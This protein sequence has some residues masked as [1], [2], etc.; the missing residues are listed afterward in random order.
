[1][2]ITIVERSVSF[3]LSSALGGATI[4]LL[5]GRKLVTTVSGVLPAARTRPV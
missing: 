1:V 2:A 5:G 4:L 3:G